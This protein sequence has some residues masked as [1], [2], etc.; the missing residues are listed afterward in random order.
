MDDVKIGDTVFLI[1]GSPALLVYHTTPTQL[2]VVWLS[3]DNMRQEAQLPIE[4]F[5]RY[6]A[7]GY[8]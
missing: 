3:K 8:K 6:N 1:T 5:S 7:I 4:C 2:C